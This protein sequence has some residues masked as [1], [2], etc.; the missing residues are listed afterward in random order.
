MTAE[1]SV[2]IV[3]RAAHRADASDDAVKTLPD[4]LSKIDAGVKTSWDNTPEGQR[5]KSCD[6]LKAKMAAGK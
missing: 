6:E 2:E 1:A 3:L 5:T 4:A